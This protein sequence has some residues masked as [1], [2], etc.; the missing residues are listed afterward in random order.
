MTST[1]LQGPTR[2][3]LA[4]NRKPEAL[5][6]LQNHYDGTHP[7]DQ[8]EDDD[9]RA[10]FTCLE[11]ALFTFGW[12]ARTG[13]DGGD[14]TALTYTGEHITDEDQALSIIACCVTEDSSMIV[15]V[16]HEGQ[17]GFDVEQW[18]FDGWHRHILPAELSFAQMPDRNPDGRSTPQLLAGL[19]KG[20]SLSLQYLLE[21]KKRKP[22]I[23]LAIEQQFLLECLLDGENSRSEGDRS[24]EQV[25]LLL[26]ALTASITHLIEAAD[27][28]D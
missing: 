18:L 11:E 25:C 19:Q 5:S 15:V 2:F 1:F 28:P 10:P 14:I 3:H 6:L 26:G 27:T 7:S 4:V 20:L 17:F 21:M 12:E 24:T 9:H 23:V 22:E 8:R 13:H 16:E